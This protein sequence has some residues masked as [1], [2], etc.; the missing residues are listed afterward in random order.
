MIIE[1]QDQ[2]LKWFYAQQVLGVIL[3]DK[4]PY[5]KVVMHGFVLDAAGSK[6]SK[7][8][9]NIVMPED[10]I[11]KYGADTLRLY[12]I[13]IV[14][15]WEDIRF[16]WDDVREIYSALNILWNVHLMAKTYME[17]DKFDPSKISDKFFD[18]YA[19][20]EDRWILSRMN[21][22]IKSIE[23]N[24][25]NCH[26][27]RAGRILINFIVDDLSRWYGK[28][29]RWRLWIERDDPVKTVAYYTLYK[30][31]RK[32]IPVL[33]LFAPFIS[34][35]I[36]QNLLRNLD[37]KLPESVFYLDWPE[38][39]YI[40][41]ELEQKME[42][43][44]EITSAVG[45]ARS[46]ARIKARWPVNEVLV[47]SDNPIVPKAIEELRD[48]LHRTLN[49][50]NITLGRIER[51]YVVKPRFDRIGPKYKGLTKQIVDRLSKMDGKAIYEA[52]MRDGRVELKVEG[53]EVVL[54]PEDIEIEIKFAEGFEGSEF[55]YGF[56]AISTKLDRKLIAEGLARDV[57]R[58]IQQMRKE[59][60]LHIEEYI[61][62]YI[63]AD[64]EFIDL[65]KEHLDY[66][67]GETRAKSITF[68]EAKGYTKKWK[69]E[70]YEVTIGIERLQ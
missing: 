35:K 54:E 48:L 29:I 47:E 49:T 57:V 23:T 4:V 20:P 26:F 36:Y 64:K 37:P 13:T 59:M 32:I 7:S 69:I 65:I 58:R 21:S 34:E 63:V 1:G 30:V 19:L 33:A 6:M 3:F 39:D 43:A 22:V 50:K 31:F 8:L 56:V 2:V 28:V 67:A 55:K 38:V 9:G 25:D 45:A 53:K 51:K 10:V 12:L 66:I 44:K 16:K 61:R 18:R 60:D 17:L 11:E 14:S 15:P 24:L 27:A 5:K 46:K 42:I 62:V 41:E 68:D 40:D 70:D 52:L